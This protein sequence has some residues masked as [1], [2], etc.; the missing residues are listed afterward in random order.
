MS[1]VRIGASESVT[2]KLRAGCPATQ[3]A[4]L[5]SSRPVV[6]AGK[7]LAFDEAGAVD[8][9]KGEPDAA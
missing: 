4:Q 3:R 1:I 2:A 5:T 6:V 9:F 7:S 8:Y